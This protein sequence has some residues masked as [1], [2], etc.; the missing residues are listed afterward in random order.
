VIEISEHLDTAMTAHVKRSVERWDSETE[1]AAEFDRRVGV[2]SDRIGTDVLHG[3][4][5]HI[6][7]G[8]FE[9]VWREVP[10]YYLTHRPNREQRAARID[11][12]LIP[13]RRLKEAGW[14]KTIGVEIKKSDCDFGAAVS[15]AIDYTYCNW[16]VGN[17][18][19]YCERIFLWPFAMPMGPLQS[20]MLQNG[21]GTV[22]GRKY[23][24]S[25]FDRALVFQLEKQ[26]ISIMPDGSLEICEAT[27][28]SRKVG[29]R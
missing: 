8:I 11:R 14:T 29:S 22:G 27:N 18:W 19:M 7:D 5:V 13:G 20:V 24:S 15:Q 26:V 6:P 10:G 4:R 12:I 3:E 21:V 28:S 25:E 2:P 17:Y 16:N 9:F 1:A 23:R